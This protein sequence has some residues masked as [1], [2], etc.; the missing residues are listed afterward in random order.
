MLYRIDVYIVDVTREIALVTDR[1]LPIAALPDAS[2]SL[3][4]A[5]T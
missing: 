2:L 3:G 1:V 4:S 5:A